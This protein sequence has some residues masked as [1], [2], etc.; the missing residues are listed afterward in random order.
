MLLS[1]CVAL[2]NTI[3]DTHITHLCQIN[4][5]LGSLTQAAIAQQKVGHGA[6]TGFNTKIDQWGDAYAWCMGNEEF[7]DQL[8][9]KVDYFMT[10]AFFLHEHI[11]V[12][13]M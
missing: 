6:A 10:Q 12:R 3:K 2:E 11:V 13:Y 1:C 7:T 4:A 8:K 5:H 9:G